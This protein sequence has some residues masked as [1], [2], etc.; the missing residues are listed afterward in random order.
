M[1][2]APAAWR[3]PS[4]LTDDTKIGQ[5]DVVD[6]ALPHVR[7]RGCVIQA[8]G[9]VGVWG[10]ALA[11]HFKRVMVFE[12]LLHLWRACVDSIVAS[13]VLVMPCALTSAT[14][15]VTISV[16]AVERFG[17]SSAVEEQGTSFPAVAMDDLPEQ[18][19][20]N[21]GA[22]MLDIEGHE[23]VALRGATRLLKQWKPVVV[24]EENA[25]S[26]R[27]RKAGA[28]AEYLTPLGYRQVADFHGDLIFSAH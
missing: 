2:R 5:P 21:L 6:L 1:K 27:Y 23:L 9:H 17:G 18:Q 12:P 14:G 24:V 10:A 15:Q 28:V 3:R 11:P 8:G 7:E 19:T 22:I 16:G 4:Y 13:N 25:K 26:L 20:A